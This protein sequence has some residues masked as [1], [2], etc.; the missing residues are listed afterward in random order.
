MEGGGLHAKVAYTPNTHNS[1]QQVLVLS[2]A[3]GLANIILF[4]KISQVRPNNLYIPV[5]EMHQLSIK[6]AVPEQHHLWTSQGHP[7]SMFPLQWM[8]ERWSQPPGS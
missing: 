4:L 2:T 5:P 3:I 1:K 6:E 8:T 7:G